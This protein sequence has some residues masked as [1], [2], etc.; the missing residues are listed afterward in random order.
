MPDIR[1]ITQ[2]L[3]PQSFTTATTG[4]SI[5]RKWLNWNMHT[6]SCFLYLSVSIC[7]TKLSLH[8]QLSASLSRRKPLHTWARYG[9]PFS[10]LFLHLAAPCSHALRLQKTRA[11]LCLMAGG[12]SVSLLLYPSLCPAA[13][14][15]KPFHINTAT[16]LIVRSQFPGKSI[17]SITV[18]GM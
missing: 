15:V 4:A 14:C 8:S 10:F 2:L 11:G 1:E 5:L 12:C 3:A 7:T 16:L 6:Y 18:T 17:S 9:R 13:V